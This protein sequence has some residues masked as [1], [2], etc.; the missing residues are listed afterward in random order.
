MNQTLLT[1]IGYIGTA[2]VL[3]S[4]LMSS[5][6]KLRILNSIGSL[7]SLFYGLLIHAYPTVI[8]NAALLLINIYFLIKHAKTKA[9]YQMVISGPED[10]HLLHFLDFYDKDIHTFFPGFKYDGKADIVRFIYCENAPINVLIANKISDT[11]IEIK[12]D[13]SNPQYRDYSPGTFLFDS[14][15]REGITKAVFRERAVNHEKYLL[16]VGFRKLED[17]TYEKVF[18]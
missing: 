1:I 4:M 5:V 6:I 2:F 10:A 16:S 17:G 14:L 15:E 9:V 7:V 8:M 12:L 11:E 3:A 18:A 13:Y